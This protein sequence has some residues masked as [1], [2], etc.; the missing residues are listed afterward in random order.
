MREQDLGFLP[1]CD[2]AGRVVGVVTDR[3]LARRVCA[4]DARASATPVR[5]IMSVGVVA[6]RPAHTVAHA[7]RQ[8]RRHKVTR[9]VI[10]DDEDRLLGVLSLSD[11]AQYVRD[12][13]TGSTLRVISERKYQPERP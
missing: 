9:I 2:E 12:A 4:E 7:E 5:D 1:V 3:D 11:V 13:Q 8:M 6:C 10:K